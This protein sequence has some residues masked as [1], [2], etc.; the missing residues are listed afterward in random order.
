MG[1]DQPKGSALAYLGMDPD[2]AR[3]YVRRLSNIA[4][5]MISSVRQL[6]SA[7]N[8]LQWSG[9]DRDRI[10]DELE[11]YSRA[12]FASME[13]IGGVAHA[14]LNNAE[15]QERCSDRSVSGHAATNA[16]TAPVGHSNTSSFTTN[17]D[18]TDY[19]DRLAKVPEGEFQILQISGPPPSYV[20]LMPGIKGLTSFDDVS[21]GTDRDLA[22]AAAAAFGMKDD[23]AARVKAALDK[24]PPGSEISF[25]AH[26]QG[27]IAAMDVVADGGYKVKD[28][29]TFGTGAYRSDDLPK[30]VN[31]T[32]TTDP[33]DPVPY[34]VEYAESHRIDDPGSMFMNAITRSTPT[35]GILQNVRDWVTGDDGYET[36]SRVGAEALQSPTSGHDISNYRSIAG[37]NGITSSDLGGEVTLYSRIGLT[38]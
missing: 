38:E 4:D 12:F 18:L 17:G 26:S 19:L 25:V 37:A 33:T 15:D 30:G 22:D 29:Y 11:S 32:V 36:V 31:L 34:L 35:T 2:Q 27:G 3:A 1:I 7:A 10:V 24:L 20:V 28:V 23:Y 6:H 21:T 8:D 9:A 13:E 14:I 5:D 16:A